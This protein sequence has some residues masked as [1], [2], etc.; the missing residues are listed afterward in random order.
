MSIKKTDKKAKLQQQTKN[1][2]N[3]K[4][5]KTKKEKIVQYCDVRAVLHSCDV[6]KE[7]VQGCDIWS[8][9]FF[10]YIGFEEC[11]SNALSNAYKADLNI[12]RCKNVQHSLWT[13]VWHQYFVA[14]PI[15]LE[16]LIDLISI[17]V[18]ISAAKQMCWI[19]RRG[20][21]AQTQDYQTTKR[22]CDF[23]QVQKSRKDSE[24]R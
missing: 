6:F 15:N 12:S 22:I 9:K 3:D 21:F 10:Q 1:W 8:G 14:R 23:L 11:A 13:F 19:L 7:K 18:L 5:T 17:W 16:Q 20:I 24:S 4:K 2:Q